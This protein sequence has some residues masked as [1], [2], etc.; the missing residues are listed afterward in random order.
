[1]DEQIREAMTRAKR[2]NKPVFLGS[3]LS[4]ESLLPEAFSSSL[5]ELGGLRPLARNGTPS[6]EPGL[7]VFLGAGTAFK[8]YL[9]PFFNAMLEFQKLCGF[10]FRRLL[11]FYRWWNTP[12]GRWRR[13][14]S[15]RP[16]RT[17]H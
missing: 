12:V 3:L 1:M 14:I 10:S 7:K 2:T 17:V 16:R 13:D 4:F 11:L 6:N 5:R 9:Y 15:R 8:S